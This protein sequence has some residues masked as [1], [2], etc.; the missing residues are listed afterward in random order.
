[1]PAAGRGRPPILRASGSAIHIA[2][3]P[4]GAVEG[5]LAALRNSPKTVGRK[6]KF[7]LATD[8]QMVEVEGLL[9]GDTVACA[10]TGLPH[11]RQLHWYLD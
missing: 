1:M 4:V 2:V 10:F 7:L 11:R 5:T 9:S 6:A 8:G 3:A